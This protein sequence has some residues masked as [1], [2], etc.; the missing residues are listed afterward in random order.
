MRLSI[1]ERD[2]FG[3]ELERHYV[4]YDGGMTAPIFKSLVNGMVGALGVDS[5]ADH[6]AALMPDGRVLFRVDRQLFEGMEHEGWITLYDCA[7]RVHHGRH[8]SDMRRVFEYMD[9][10]YEAPKGITLS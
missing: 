9:S 1:V 4:E 5:K 2:I 3:F 7:R 8:Y 10:R 6:M